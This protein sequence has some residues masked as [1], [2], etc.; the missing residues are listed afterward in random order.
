MKKEESDPFYEWKKKEERFEEINKNKPIPDE[1]IAEQ[2]GY[3]EE[4]DTKKY[5]TLA[6]AVWELYNDKRECLWKLA[7]CFI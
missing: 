4:W 1:L 2:I 6:S 3:P 7:D 5:P